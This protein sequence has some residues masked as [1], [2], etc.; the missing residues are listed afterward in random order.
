[1]RQEAKGRRGIARDKE[2]GKSLPASISLANY[3]LS[4]ILD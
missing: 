4:V 2:R 3:K 1:M